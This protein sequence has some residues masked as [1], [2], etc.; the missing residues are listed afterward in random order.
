[1]QIKTWIK[2]TLIYTLVL[3]FGLILGFSGHVSANSYLNQSFMPAPEYP[4]NE[5]GETY[6]SALKATSPANEPD[7][8]KAIGEDG[9][10]GYVR[11]SDLVGK[12]P[13]TPEEAIKMNT[14]ACEK[15]INLYASDG[16]TVIGK[17]KIIKGILEEKK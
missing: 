5:Y 17:F 7:L 15:E 4:K 10:I 1:M 3:T 16:K 14:E 2:H 8:I 13:K 12:Q 6:G 9:T 11:N